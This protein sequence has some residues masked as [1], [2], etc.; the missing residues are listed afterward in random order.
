MKEAEVIIKYL[1]TAKNN[2]KNGMKKEKLK[3]L[4]RDLHYIIA[5]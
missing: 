4:L 1:T 3:Y 5:C 2:D